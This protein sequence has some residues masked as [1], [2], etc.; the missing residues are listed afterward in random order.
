MK[1]CA[2][3]A[4][5]SDESQARGDS[6][7]HQIQFCREIAKRRSIEDGQEWV[8]LDALVYVDE[9]ITGTSMV[10]RPE[11]QRLIRDARDHQFDV[12]L[13]K[14]ISRFARDTV[15]A[16]IMLRTLIA[17][18][19]RVLS[20]EENFDSQRDNAEFVFTI[21]SALAQAESEKTAIRVRMGAT[22]KAKAGKWN[23][24]TPDGYVLNKR[25]QHLEIDPVRAHLI[26]E[27]FHLYLCGHGARSIVKLLNHRGERTKSGNRWN[28]RTVTRILQNPAYVGDVLYGRRERTIA[29][30]R[31]NADILE[32]RKVARQVTNPEQLVQVQNAHPP[33]VDR[34]TFEAVS[35]TL[36]S[37]RE[38]RGRSGGLHLLSRG[39]LYCRCGNRMVVK[40]N[41]RGIRYYHCAKQ[42]VCGRS[43]CKQPFIRA[44]EVETLV[45]RQLRDD[46]FGSE[47][48]PGPTDAAIDAR[49]DADGT[50]DTK[51]D[52]PTAGDIPD[53]DRQMRHAAEERDH[54][55]K[56]SQLLFEEYVVGSISRAQFVTMNEVYRAQIASLER[57]V[58]STPMEGREQAAKSGDGSP[59]FQKGM[60]RLL[61]VPPGCPPNGQA[62]QLRIV[63][64]LLQ[65]CIEKVQVDGHYLS[66]SYRF[67]QPD[68]EHLLPDGDNRTTDGHRTI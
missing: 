44:D 29:P 17:S 24:K 55:L 49:P 8:V 9:A 38:V 37:R 67:E 45:L 30:P 40:Y 27:I 63:R 33:L 21:H 36:A 3:Y 18:R 4:R 60:L 20:L 13:F 43:Q 46:L 56:V 16:L 62:D 47:R 39:I 12:V 28:A 7:Q 66:I 57:R 2:I 65:K 26:Q 10:K 52:D 25:T 5:V 35:A 53:L 31:D 51:T 22:Q 58:K 1:R 14:G 68:R 59:F 42:N 23:G 64:A 34:G 54:I 41:S 50:H 61:S 48:P 32:R 6:T 11:V 15:D 19:V